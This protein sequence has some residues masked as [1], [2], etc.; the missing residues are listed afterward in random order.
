MY[1]F[2]KLV[3]VNALS[4]SSGAASVAVICT[5]MQPVHAHNPVFPYEAFISR[6]RFPAALGV[7]AGTDEFRS[8]N[9][10]DG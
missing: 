1:L 2:L 9:D 6:A 3:Q 7:H 8:D 5:S 10:A 4:R